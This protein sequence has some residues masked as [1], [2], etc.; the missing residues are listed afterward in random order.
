MGLIAKTIKSAID[1]VWEIT[2]ELWPDFNKKARL[3]S[4]P[5]IQG[6]PLEDDE[7][8]L[9]RI[10]SDMSKTAFIGTFHKEDIEPGEV[11]VYSRDAN[12]DLIAK[13][14]CD[15]DGNV[16]INADS[17]NAVR[18]SELKTAFD[19]LKS[20]FSSFVTT[21]YN[22]HMHPTAATGA[23]SLPTITGSSSTADIDPAKIDT[24]KV[25]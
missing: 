21:Q 18:F 9:I 20:D 24:I 5:G 10:G 22:L 3:V 1:G 12:G 13:V 8:I 23:A 16:T 11:I 14:Y 15:K 6:I 7:C 19:Q 4:S 2:S 25:P 17:D